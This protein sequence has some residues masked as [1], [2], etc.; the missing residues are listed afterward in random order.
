VP[1]LGSWGR[2]PAAVPD[3]QLGLQTRVKG[4]NPYHPGLTE[5]VVMEDSVAPEPATD[6]TTTSLRGRGLAG[7]GG[8]TGLGEIP[9]RGGTA[10]RA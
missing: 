7:F 10:G 9:I 3:A 8:L 5:T 6:M 1:E 2:F 4:G